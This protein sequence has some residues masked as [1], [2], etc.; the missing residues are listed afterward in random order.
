MW[1][2]EF[3]KVGN[4]I[5]HSEHFNKIKPFL[6]EVFDKF[7]SEKEDIIVITHGYNWNYLKIYFKIKFG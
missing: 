5:S 4:G 6:D 3:F 1:E 7:K 2:D